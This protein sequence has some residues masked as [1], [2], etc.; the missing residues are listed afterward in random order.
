LSNCIYA[1][2]YIDCNLDIFLIEIMIMTAYLYT[3]V[4]FFEYISLNSIKKWYFFWKSSILLSLHHVFDRPW[5]MK[6]FKVYLTST[7]QQH[8]FV[9]CYLLTIFVLWL[10][11][12]C[13]ISAIVNNSLFVNDNMGIGNCKKC[14]FTFLLYYYGNTCTQ[15]QRV[16]CFT[17]LS[18]GFSL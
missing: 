6:C 12:K 2:I 17:S 3:Y 5:K 7:I 13:L 9:N 16:R 10:W 18:L 8:G 1:Y 11:N 15:W 14:R 4:G